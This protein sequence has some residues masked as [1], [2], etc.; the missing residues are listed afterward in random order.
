MKKIMFATISLVFMTVL[1]FSQEVIETYDINKDKQ[2]TV[3]VRD[4]VESDK[5]ILDQ[6]DLDDYTVGEEVYITAEMWK[7]I[8]EQQLD[9]KTNTKPEKVEV[10]LQDGR[11]SVQAA[12]KV[13]TKKDEV[14]IVK[15]E[16]VEKKTTKTKKTTSTSKK[17]ATKR[18]KSKRAKKYRYKKSKRA[19]RRRIGRRSSKTTCY[20]F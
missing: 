10:V 18:K 13:E 7:E 11:A 17:K 1:A 14:E 16:K 8:Q 2:T 12:T 4:S 3:I 20:S 9:S 19:K 6:L 15:E 5:D